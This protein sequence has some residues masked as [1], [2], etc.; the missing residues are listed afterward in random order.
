[1]QPQL[2][3][4]GALLRLSA[5][6]QPGSCLDSP[7]AHRSQGPREGAVSRSVLPRATVRGSGVRSAELGPVLQQKRSPNSQK[8]LREG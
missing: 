6:R 4:P 2:L 8:T 1:M 3:I 7:S 5:F